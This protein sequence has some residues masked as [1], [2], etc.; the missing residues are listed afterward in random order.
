MYN[1][2]KLFTH[3]KV[4]FNAVF[5]LDVTDFLSYSQDFISPKLSSLQGV[6]LP[7]MLSQLSL[8]GKLQCVVYI[9]KH[10]SVNFKCDVV[11]S[12]RWKPNLIWSL[13]KRYHL[14]ER[15]IE[16]K[17]ERKTDPLTK[18]RK[19]PQRRPPE[20]PTKKQLRHISLRRRRNG[21]NAADY[22]QMR[23]IREFSLM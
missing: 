21:T 15:E 14:T 23:G 6:F 3:N 1:I 11:S 7:Q 12:C 8:G 18:R 19:N 13:S 9:I 16:K 4:I 2:P 10:S 17:R 5:N 22:L 20:P